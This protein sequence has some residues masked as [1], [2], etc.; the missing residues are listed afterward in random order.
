MPS[1]RVALA[2]T[3]SFPE[4]K[5]AGSNARIVPPPGAVVPDS[6]STVIVPLQVRRIASPPS[7]KEVR[8]T[9]QPSGVRSGGP[10]PET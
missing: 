3:A 5:T 4:A 6:S 9:T 1:A 2:E 7:A 10:T 8:A